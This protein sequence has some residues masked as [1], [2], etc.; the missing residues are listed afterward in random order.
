MSKVVS[1]RLTEDQVERLHRAA[2]RS[3]RKVSETAALMIEEGLRK[4]EFPEIEIRETI[5][6]REAF[7]RG[8]R[9][10]VWHVAMHRLDGDHEAARIAEALGFHEYEIQAALDYMD[11]YP[12]EIAEA[13]EDN[14]RRFEEE[15]R[16][17]PEELK[18]I[19]AKASGLQA[20]AP[21]S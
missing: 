11:A 2:H 6:G 15:S 17:L 5:A 7:I 18:R 10:K 21:A 12:D 3:G 1:F 4:R 13:L 14:H 20:D 19:R 9:L 8:T 16:S